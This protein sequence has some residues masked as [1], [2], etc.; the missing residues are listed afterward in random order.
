MLRMRPR[1]R[2]RWHHHHGWHLR[3]GCGVIRVTVDVS[4]GSRLR[5][6][7]MGPDSWYH[8]GPLM[9]RLQWGLN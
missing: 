1:R 6:P 8:G 7:R 2:N 4:L 3:R 5:G 9:M